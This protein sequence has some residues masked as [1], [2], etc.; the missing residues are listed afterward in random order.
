VAIEVGVV[1]AAL[2]FMYRMSNVTQLSYFNENSNPEDS[3]SISK[4]IIPNGVEVFEINGSFFFGAT[5]RFKD[6]LKSLGQT[7]KVLILRMRHVLTIDATGIRA[8]EDIISKCNTDECHVILS[9]VH[10]Q[11]YMALE[12]SKTLKMID[13]RNICMDIDLS[14]ER[15]HEILDEVGNI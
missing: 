5:D 2:L 4:K 10:A 1:M 13:E 11:P 14:L 7:P 8:L 12:K 15:A 3:L 6:E 9:G